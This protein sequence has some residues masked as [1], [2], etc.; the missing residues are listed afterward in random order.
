MVTST[1]KALKGTPDTRLSTL[2]P[3]RRGQVLC[4]GPRLPGP[5]PPPRTGLLCE[6]SLAC[7]SRP[8][9]PFSGSCVHLSPDGCQGPWELV[10]VC[11]V[12]ALAAH[13]SDHEWEA[14]R[15]WAELPGGHRVWSLPAQP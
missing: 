1:P 11:S 4:L 5:Q 10:A 8:C 2:P 15:P 13:I 3:A 12:P 9:P 6:A 7:S 14:A